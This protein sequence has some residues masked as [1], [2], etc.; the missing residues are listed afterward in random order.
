MQQLVQRLAYSLILSSFIMHLFCC[1]IPLMMSITSL[2]ALVGITS[3]EMLHHS[4]FG[5]YEVEL[6]AV[7][8]AILFFTGGLQWISRRIDCRTD[9][10]CAHEPCDPKKDL[11][12]HIFAG[13]A[14]LY[15]LNLAIFF[16]SHSH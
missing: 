13:A 16:L 14:T 8:G 10:H 12:G 5:R 4:W 15:L 6:L 2:T 11:S 7:S 3:G 1:G 9:G